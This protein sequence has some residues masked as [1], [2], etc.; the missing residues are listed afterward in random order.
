MATKKY[1]S[2][3]NLT[4]FFNNL[5]N[6]FA[7]KSEVSA[8][9]NKSHSHS[10]SDITNLQ[11][12]LDGKANSSH[13]THVNYSTTAPVMDGTASTGSATTVARSDHRHPTDTSR[14]AQ[15][16][17]DTHTSN[18]TA[19]ITSAERTNWG[20]GYTHSQSAHAPSN[21]EK[22]QNAFSNIAISGQTTVSADT[23]TDTLTFA[24][25]NVSITT[26]A[27]NDKVTFSVANGS[28]SAKGIVQLT[29]STS[30]TST[31]TAA[32]PNSVKSAYDLANQAKTA[33]TNAQ[34]TAD[35]KAN[36][37]HTHKVADIS[38][39]TVSA[40]EL[41]YMD[42]V[43]SGVQA[44]LDSKASSGHTHSYAGSSSTGGAATSANKLNTNAGSA[45]QP[46][47]F[48]NGVPV[49]TTYT[50]GK[51]VPSNADFSNTHYTSKNVVGATNATSNTATVLTNGN[52][53]INSVENGAVTS[54][55]KISGSGATIV[56]TDDKGNIIISSTD[57]NTTYS[58]AGSSLGLVKSGGDVTISSGVITVNDDSHNHTI[59]NVDNLQASLDTKQNTITGGATTIVSSN[60]TANRALISNG[61]G[62][63]AVSDITN[64]E[65][66]Y[67][68]GVSSN[69]QNQLNGKVTSTH[70][71]YS[72]FETASTGAD[73]WYTL[74]T[75]NDNA[76]GSA[77]CLLKGYAH[78]SVIF[79]V[80]KG[81][82]ANASLNIL[83]CN[84]SLNNSYAHIKALR[85]LSDGK[86]Q[87]QI[88]TGT[89]NINI[90]I[91]SA[92]GWIT[93]VSSLVCDT[94][95]PTV[96]VTRTLSH[97]KMISGGFIGD[98]SGNAAT[99]T[100]VAWSGVTSK[101]SYYDAKAIKSITRSGTTFTYT[102][103]D[104][105]TG[106]FTQQDNNTTYSAATTSANG[107]MSS[108]D[109]TKLD[110]VESGANKYTHPT[111]TARTGVPTSNQTPAFG[112]TFTVTQPTSDSTGHITAMN[113]RTITI[114]SSV[115]TTSTAGLMSASDKTKLNTM[116][117]ATV[118]EVETYL[119]I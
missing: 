53:Y 105:T 11:N 27:T 102:C 4:S 42:G 12:T 50:L 84:T 79:T 78:S 96:C 34:T 99:A 104:G 110:G 117:L 108:S 38:D 97:G 68:D 89:V 112:G 63:V 86:V 1:I 107:L 69:I 85:I 10:I 111:Y 14:A 88:N 17:L 47:Y 115:A 16:S 43:S 3:S 101:P 61:S 13:G 74:F 49:A 59:A 73:G 98:L 52:V 37:S 57:N 23:V 114:P 19:H 55:H 18:T 109:K 77:I 71:S 83:D 94:S 28:T 36:A 6:I 82:A 56:T 113:S 90:H 51:S 32:T 44:Q 65:L 31:T 9:A 40:A 95:S 87:A 54:S 46:V 5:K 45:T 75:I 21:A 20:T 70:K 7:T 60:L 64:T 35:G 48:A 33:A 41:N 116:E 66:G 2:F 15:T 100:N 67:L 106:T 93:P 72:S 62:K 91:I 81:Y 24:G 22:N 30:S 58:A 80:T 119:A 103:M 76:N 8:K 25:S 26:D 29:N 92:N 118:S 39:L